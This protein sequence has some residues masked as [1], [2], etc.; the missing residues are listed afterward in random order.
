MAA[1]SK[2]EEFQRLSSQ[3]N[4]W[5]ANRLDIFEISL[6]NEVNRQTRLCTCS[7]VMAVLLPFLLH[8]GVF[9]F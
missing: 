9:Y 8:H 7:V 4:E 1:E 2:H 5:N 3:I 6:P